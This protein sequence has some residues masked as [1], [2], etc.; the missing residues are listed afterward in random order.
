MRSLIL[1]MLLMQLAAAA[2][3]PLVANITLD[4]C[5][6]KCG[7]VDVPYPFGTSY[8]CHQ[9]GF[10]VTCDRASSPPK[11]FLGGDG[12]S[13]WAWRC[14]RSPSRTERCASTQWSG[15]SPLATQATP[16]CSPPIGTAL[17]SLAAGSRPLHGRRCVAARSR[18][19]PF[20][21]YCTIQDQQNKVQPVGQCAGVGCCEA[22][23]P[24][25]LMS[26]NIQFMWL[27]KNTTAR[28][29]WMVPNVSV[30][31]S[32]W[33]GVG[34]SSCTVTQT[35]PEF[36]CVSKN[37]ECINSTSS[38]Y[39]YVCRCNDGY[40]GNPYVPDGC[41]GSLRKHVTAG[42]FLAIGIGIG[43]RLSIRKAKKMREYF[44]NQNRGLLLRQLGMALS[45]KACCQI[46]VLLPL[47]KS[48]V[49]VQ[50]EID[51]F[52]NE[53]AILSQ[54]NNRNVVKLF[55]CCLETEVPL[56]VYEFISN[57]TLYAHLHVDDPQKP[58][59]WK[60]R[61]QIAFE[62]ASSLA[63]LHSA[64]TTSVVHRDIKTTNILLDDWLIVKIS[65]FGASRGISVD[66]SVVTTGITGTHGYLD[67]EYFY[68][69]RLTEKSD[70][71]NYGVILVEL[72]TRKKPSVYMS[73]EGV[74]LVAHFIM[75]LNQDKLSEMLKCLRLKG[76]IRL[77][78]RNVEMRLQRLQ[79]SDIDISGVE[80]HPTYLG[81]NGEASYNYCTSL[82]R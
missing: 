5:E 74:S 40:D 3:M 27:D 77:T 26:F 53:V 50:K 28:P 33:T 80:E 18:H 44:F 68:T 7:E 42:V 81:S 20:V 43:L 61:L 79:G 36:G 9:R 71:Y 70:A 56:L 32:C 65:D 11:P 15:P 58:L 22:A 49:V 55:G 75:L 57:G 47:K 45:T 72:L 17:S 4:G 34:Q 35:R 48:R 21:S 1:P 29:P 59:L 6:R 69:G 13:E 2:A 14:W 52:I 46:S 41:Q 73:P 37:S 82:E 64:A 23:I 8:G 39:G 63:Y 19:V 12:V 66:Q 10:M 30:L 76:Q 16:M 54:V 25:G 60:N 38:A 67:P 24:T 31:V 51:E 78:K 62:V